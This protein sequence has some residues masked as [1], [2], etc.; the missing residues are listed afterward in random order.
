MSSP[1]S[2][3]VTGAY[4]LTGNWLV[5]RLLDDGHQVVVL[6]R[7]VLARSALVLEGLERRLIVV[8][9]DVTD[10]NLADRVLAQYEIDTVFHLA[11][12]PIVGT[13]GRSPVSTLDT[14]VRGTWL[15]L[16][17]CRTHGVERIVVASSPKVYAPDAPPPLREDLP[18]DPHGPYEASK[19]ATELVALGYARAFGLPVAITRCANVYGGGDLNGSRIVPEAVTAALSGRSPAIRSDGSPRRDFLYVEDA[20][21]AYLAI[22]DA[23]DRGVAT[24]EAFNVG[25]GPRHSVLEVVE[26]VCRAAGSQV[27]PEVQGGSPGDGPQD[28]WLDATKLREL[29]GWEPRVDLAEGVRRTVD[30]YRA[31]PDAL[32]S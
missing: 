17:A 24:G 19:A 3:Y 30:W 29:T 20:V 15:T 26:E 11:S 28:A 12:Q 16:E 7:D 22:A 1:R 10:Q 14:N 18:L 25:G 31:N 4:G 32:G 6:K 2:V 27:S 13:A 23:L 9:G 21:D 5:R 8:L